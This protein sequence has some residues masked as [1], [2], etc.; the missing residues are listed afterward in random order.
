MLCKKLF[1]LC[2]ILCFAFATAILPV[3]TLYAQNVEDEMRSPMSR[4]N[5]RGYAKSAS[6]GV[7]GNEII[8][9]Y[10]GGLML[11]YNMPV[12]LPNQLGGDVT[13]I[14]NVNTE[15][16][17]FPTVT[18]GQPL[19][20]AYSVN[21]PEWIIGYK[22]IALQVLNFPVNFWAGNFGTNPGGPLA[23]LLKGEHVPYIVPG[24]HYCN[25]IDKFNF[26]NDHGRIDKRDAISILMADGS[27]KVFINVVPFSIGPKPDTGTYV[28]SGVE[29]ASYALV[30]KNPNNSA[31]RRM[32]YYPG[33]GLI[34]LFVEEKIHFNDRKLPLFEDIYTKAFYLKQI[35][36][37]N[38]ETVTFNYASR[39]TINPSGNYGPDTLG[40]KLC[41]GITVTG[42]NGSQGVVNLAYSEIGFPGS[43]TLNYIRITNSYGCDTLLLGIDRTL[44][45][46][47]PWFSLAKDASESASQ[48]KMV[49]AIIKNGELKDDFQYRVWYRDIEHSSNSITKFK[50]RTP[51]YTLESAKYSSGSVS[52]FRFWGEN[53]L[54]YNYNDQGLLHYRD[55]NTQLMLLERRQSREIGGISQPALYENY[56]YTDPLVHRNELKAREDKSIITSV[57]S[58]RYDQNGNLLDTIETVKKFNKYS[59]LGSHLYHGDI[60]S[61]TRLMEETQTNNNEVKTLEYEYEIGGMETLDGKE[62]R[63]GSMQMSR[64]TEKRTLAGVS[65]ERVTLFLPKHTAG[66]GFGGTI[67]KLTKDSVFSIFPDGYTTKTKYSSGNLTFDVDSAIHAMA[68]FAD[69][70]IEKIDGS[71]TLWYEYNGAG[72]VVR[73]IADPGTKPKITTYKYKHYLNA[74]QFAHSQYNPA[75]TF[76]NLLESVEMP[77]GVKIQYKYFPD[78]KVDSFVIS[79]DPYYIPVHTATDSGLVLTDSIYRW[80]N[81]KYSYGIK[82]KIAFDNA[83]ISDTSIGLGAPVLD[84]TPLKTIVVPVNGD[85]LITEQILNASML[86]V[87]EKDVNGFISKYEYDNLKRPVLAVFPGSF[88]KETVGQGQQVHYYYKNLSLPITR[89]ITYDEYYPS[90]RPNLD[91]ILLSK[92]GQFGAQEL[93]QVQI[94]ADDAGQSDIADSSLIGQDSANTEG[95]FG[96]ILHKFVFCAFIQTPLQFSGGERVNS[97]KLSFFSGEKVGG[98]SYHDLKIGISA[99]TQAINT[100]ENTVNFTTTVEVPSE[101]IFIDS[102]HFLVDVA[103]LISG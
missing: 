76:N 102:T 74:D 1:Q 56:Y 52:H 92:D 63:V 99:V 84:F 10:S 36:N 21:L 64:Q 86:P 55:Q 12:N 78:T 72:Q 70:V 35:I 40:R 96:P 77:N 71:D 62:Y 15:H 68:Y 22:G 48:I 7:N 24:Y 44:G 100:A 87:F 69:R 53:Y 38:K 18:P 5:E 88:S 73:Q 46:G 80:N 20:Q 59:L 75:I 85:T 58:K 54:S 2:K 103:P 45:A 27:K 26:E 9:D 66:Y 13:V 50:F 91:V 61:V 30:R 23:G 3:S 49:S 65:S 43:E 93:D 32:W 82:G 83:S 41:T 28:A 25:R 42:I 4:F 8:T 90:P 29:D 67:K 37:P 101:F 19:T 31:L 39:T 6:F 97:A 79:P 57:C 51:A 95:L 94:L 47:S 16:D 17:V 89:G 81:A 60:Q 33:D 34:Y 98:G 11:Q 14:Y